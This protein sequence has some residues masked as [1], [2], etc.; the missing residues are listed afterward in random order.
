[1][2]SGIA[3]YG[4][5]SIHWINDLQE[6]TPELN[7]LKANDKRIRSRM[8]S[9]EPGRFILVTGD[10]TES[11]LQKAEQAYLILDQLKAENKLNDYFGLYPWILS[12]QLQQQNQH[13]F[14]QRL[15]EQVKANWK[16]ALATQGLSVAKLGDLNYPLAEPLYFQEVLGS[17]VRRLLDSQFVI[18]AK[19]TLIMIWIAEHQPEALRAAFAEI[20]GAQYFSQ[21]DL[22][23]RM[24]TDYRDRAQTML[25]VGISVII[26]LLLLRYKSLLKTVQ[27][28]LPAF[29]AALFILGGW[30][31]TGQAV[32]FLHLV[33]FLLAVA[34]CVDYGIFYREN[35]GGNI[36]L[37]Y[38]AMSASMLTSALAFGCLF[39]ADTS[40]LRTLAGVVALGVMLG[41]LLCPIIINHSRVENT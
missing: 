29:V 39:F 4:V 14:N 30:S 23:N 38:Q 32:S 41:F 26:L 28:L 31:M 34:I 40:T 15:T 36:C 37:T 13:W 18:G 1:M 2:L 22:L 19:Q 24:A 33:G 21:R 12:E 20:E 27:T 11:A 16:N 5:K 7:T 25:F 35:R 3:L 6:L 9:I 10:N 8:I 17:P